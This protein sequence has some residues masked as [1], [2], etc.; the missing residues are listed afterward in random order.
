MTYQ[1]LVNQYRKKSTLL[2]VGLDTDITRLPRHILNEDD[3]VFAF[4]KQIID[5]TADC[6]I[7]Y[8]P[9]LAFYEARGARGWESLQKTVEYIPKDIF[10]IADAKRGDIGNTAG[11][12]AKAFFEEMPFDAVTI[13]PYMGRDS[14]D[15]FLAYPDKWVILLAKTS[16]ASS[17]DFQE[18]YVGEDY[19]Y[20]Q[21]I[22]ISSKWGG[23]DQM[24]Y[25]VGATQPESLQVIR[26]MVP[27]HFFLVP[28]VGAQGG[29]ME[30]VIRY[31]S[32][33]DGGLLINSSRQIIYASP[34]KDFAKAAGNEARK[35]QQQMEQMLN[36]HS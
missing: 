26:K 32:T 25:V 9:N 24:M 14:V 12:Y 16:N 11:M 7:A 35:L 29:N 21:V 15:P 23:K 31:G 18:L 10:T 4:N 20:Q 19:L 28:G 6:C 33:G 2:C 36:K 17:N 34:G 22:E 3:P 5:A 30:E 13:A 27:D 8:K 1:E